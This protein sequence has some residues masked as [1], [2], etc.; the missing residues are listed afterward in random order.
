MAIE[1]SNDRWVVAARR[2]SPS[3]VVDLLEFVGPKVDAVFA[4]VDMETPGVAVA[5]TGDGPS[6]CWL[7]I[8]REYAER[9]V[10]HAQIRLAVAAVPLLDRRWFFPVL[11]VFM[12]CLPRAY[13]DIGA[14]TGSIVRVQV[15]GESGGAWFVQRLPDR[16]HLVADPGTGPAAEVRVDP[17]I[18][19]RL[20]SRTMTVEAALPE[21]AIAGDEALARAITRA[22]AIM[23]SR[24]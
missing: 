11:D 1:K 18:A 7:D 24:L 12:R 22:V 3:L 21:I 17:D 9:W 10:H 16:W 20:L 14:P 19:W 13:E 5:W 4:A 2:I 8:A 23:T 15:T 6:P